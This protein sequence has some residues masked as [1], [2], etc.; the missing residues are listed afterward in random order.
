M[1]AGWWTKTL[2]PVLPQIVLSGTSLVV[3]L[4]RL[5]ASLQEVW[6][7]SLVWELRSCMPH[8]TAKKK[9]IVLSG[10]PSHVIP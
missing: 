2:N 6:V 3:Q 10:E 8:S 9:E 1:K 7:W 5:H 4:L